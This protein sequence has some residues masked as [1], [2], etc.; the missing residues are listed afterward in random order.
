MSEQQP[1]GALS[2]QQIMAYLPHRYPFLLIDKIVEREGVERAVGVKQLTCNEEF[3][4]GHFPE[5]PEMP[6]SL[7]LEAMAQVGAAVILSEPS[8]A[9]K[10]ILFGSLDNAEF[11]RPA[12]PGETLE[13]EARMLNF[14]KDTGKTRIVCRSA[15]EELAS[16]D[17]VFALTSEVA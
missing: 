6:Q 8:C 17:F 2:I 15:G 1:N 16:A 5:H 11:G 12:E 10:Y 7:M 14:R 9:G 4:Q 13:I 3:F